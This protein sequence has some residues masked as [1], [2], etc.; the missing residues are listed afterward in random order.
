MRLHLHTV[1][2]TSAILFLL[3]GNI[4]AQWIS[5]V[6]FDDSDMAI[7]L[8]EAKSFQK[9]PTYDQYLQMMQDFASDYPAIC[10]LDTFGYSEEGRMLL[11]LKLSDNVNEYEP[12]ASFLYSSTMHGNE[13]VGYVLL[14]RLADSLLRGYGHDEEVTGLLDNLQIWINPLANPDGSFSNDNNLS[15]ENASRS[16]SLGIDLNRNF[17]DPGSG[18]KDD[19]EGRAQETRYM[20]ELMREQ[21]FTLSANIHSGE[22]VVNYPWDYAPHLHV[23]DNWFRFISREYA[24]EAKAV[25]PDY[26]FGWDNGITNGWQWYEARGTRQDY[27]SYYLGGR[28]VTLEL[29][30][31]YLLPSDELEH[32]WNINERSLFNYLA[33]CMYGIRGIVTDQDTGDPLRARIEVI[34][35]DSAYSVVYSSASHGGFYRLIKEGVY[36]LAITSDGYF[37]DTIRGVSVTDYQA[38]YLNV[39]LESWPLSVREIPLPTLQLYPNPSSGILYL[40][41]LHLPPGEL[42]LDILSLDGKTLISKKLI[43]QGE[44]LPLDMHGLENGMYFVQVTSHAHRMIDRVLI[45]GP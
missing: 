33:Q 28:E 16:N 39:Q 32:Y 38:S 12:E 18:D 45:I 8:S 26:M 37:D 35:H 44:A 7:D 30:M 5:E 1:F 3:S 36:D 29:S 17:P 34:D 21:R 27:I 14:L 9:Y 31:D 4:S 41:A 2:A 19:T 23:D 42:R 20:M 24:D 11:A 10:R 15:L 22:E 13:I 25:D 40:E 43:W 6:G